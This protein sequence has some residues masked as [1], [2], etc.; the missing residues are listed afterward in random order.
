MAYSGNN[1]LYIEDFQHYLSGRSGQ[2]KVRCPFCDEMRSDKRDKSLSIDATTYLYH[3]HYCQ[4]SGVLRSKMGE[5]L[6]KDQRNFQPKKKTYSRPAKKIDPE[7]KYSESFLSF[8]ANRCISEQTLRKAKVT[9]ETEKMPNVGRVGVIAF[10]YYLNGELVNVKYRTRD[11]GF[12]LISGAQIIPYNLD[13][14]EAKSFKEGEDKHCFITEGEMDALTLIECGYQHA[15]SAPNGGSNKNME[16]LDDFID[17][18]FEPLDYIYICVDNDNVGMGFRHELIRRFGED[19]CRIIDYPAPCK[20][21]NEVLMK[22]GK[23]SVKKCVE[24]YTELRPDGIQELVDVE[25]SLDD[26]FHNGLQKGATV[27]IPSVD[28]IVSF[29]TGMLNVVTGVPS[30]GKALHI[31]EP[32]KTPNGWTTMG[33]VKVG[34]EL[35]DENGNICKVTF[36]TPIMYNHKCYKLTFSDGSTVVC[37]AEHIWVTR[38]DKARRSEYQYQK[39]VRKNG[40]TEIMRRGTDQSNKRTFPQ[41]RTAEEIANTLYVENGKRCNHAVR[42]AKALEGKQQSLLVEPYLLGVWLADG[43]ASTGTTIC[44]GDKEVIDRIASFGYTV[45]KHKYK[46]NYGIHNLAWKLKDLGLINNKRIPCQYLNSTI[47]DRIELLKGLM[48]S[49]GYIAKD[50]SC[51]YYSSRKDLAEDVYELVVSLGMKANFGSKQATLYGV[52]KKMCYIVHFSPLFD[53]FTLQRKSERIKTKYNDKVNWRY[54]VKAEE[55][56]SVPV[57]CIQVDS[58]SHLYL[59]GKSMIPTH[60]TYMLNYLLI[61]LNLIHD[62]KVAFFSPEFYPVSLHISQVIETMGGQRFSAQNYNYKTYE[63]MKSY[64]CKN[65]FFIDPNDTDIGSVL[66]RAKYL[67]RKKGIKVL[68]IDPF[69]ALTD[70]ERKSVKQDEYISEFL[71]KLRW[72]A[73]KFDIAIFLVMH[74]VKQKKLDNGL[75]PVCD[76][77]D[78][79]GASEIFDK[80]DMGITVWRNHLEDYAEMHITKIKFRHLGEKGKATFK[81]NTRNGRYVEIES[82]EDVKQK[83]LDMRTLPVIWDDS[84]YILQ[85]IQDSQMQTEL[86]IDNSIKT[87]AMLKPNTDFMPR[88]EADPLPWESNND[89]YED[90][91][92]PF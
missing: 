44:T 46:Y 87:Q 27:G 15:I 40:T 64:M 1:I 11:K 36:C 23:D 18:H 54:I 3:C 81:F 80:A 20:D 51:Y 74:P 79:K 48:D 4:A 14:I 83:G 29:K 2:V 33:D 60:N 22:Y 75:Y 21:I 91:E 57:K 90:D 39:R 63:A 66:D 70:K 47:N 19:K 69:N 77:Y 31:D 34:D 26:I 52:N 37:D 86:G 9:Q 12:K 55:V 8:F 35:Y 92:T 13:A 28:K 10:N 7:K 5:I 45:T 82:A 53:C 59:C 41:E 43:V 72:F 58:P 24:N 17:S 76:L 65:F 68:V 16:F 42:V 32:L 67:I 30:H 85:K 88:V 62:W 61:K 73:R 49:D 38:D 50:G 6:S 84:N 71:Q 25:S 56:D 78:C 89:Y